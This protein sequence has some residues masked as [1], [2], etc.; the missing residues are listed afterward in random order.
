MRA[1]FLAAA[2][3]AFGCSPS[4][5]PNRALALYAG[6]HTELFDDTIEPAAVGLDLDKSF[7]ARSDATLRERAQVGDAVVRVR[8]DTVTEKPEGSEKGYELRLRVLEKLAGKNPPEENTFSVYLGKESPSIGIMNHFGAQLV[9]KT[10]IGFV[11]LFNNKVGEREY[12]FHLSSDDKDVRRAVEDAM[13]L[14]ELKN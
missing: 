8:L 3:T 9:G 10:F 2:L 7:N 4:T 1:L 6:H 5:G 11:R 14:K 12:H 13:A